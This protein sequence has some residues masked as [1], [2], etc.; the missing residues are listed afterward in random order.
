MRNELLPTAYGVQSEFISLIHE[1]CRAS[2]GA[3]L[4]LVAIF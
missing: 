4:V 2:L 1:A 3:S